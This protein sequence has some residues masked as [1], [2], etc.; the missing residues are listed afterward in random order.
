MLKRRVGLTAVELIVAIA[1][2]GILAALLLPAIQS[3]REAARRTSCMNNLK[4]IGLALHSYDDAHSCLPLGTVTRYPSVQAAFDV[5]FSQG[6][7]FSSQLATPETPWLVPLLPYLEQGTAAA[8][9]D[10]NAGTFG[11]VDLKPPFLLSGLN[12]NADV[13]AL[14]VPVLRCSSDRYSPFLYDT[15]ELIGQPIGAPVAECS[16]GNYAAN[17]GNTTWEQNADLDGDRVADPGV[18]FYMAPF[19]RGRSTRLSEV[20]DG[21]SSTVF[22]SEVANGVKIDARGAVLT[23]LPGGSL[24]MSRLTP[25]GSHDHYNFAAEGSGDQMPFPATCNA[26]SQIPCRFDARRFTAF[27]GARSRHLGGVHSLTG[28]GSVRFVSNS[29]DGWIWISAHS[30]A[31]GAPVGEF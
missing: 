7:V 8:R 12:A 21:L 4:Q 6:G 9:F 28:S 31:Q 19:G 22:V 26:A 17:W 2:L 10:A 23:P 1:I 16:R 29:V 3:A 11:Y 14:A 30:I 13:L 15:N 5:L 25:N 20:R 18:T 24:Y 27:A